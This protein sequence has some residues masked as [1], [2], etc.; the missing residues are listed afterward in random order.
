MFETVAD[1]I[2]TNGLLWG[3]VGKKI[4]SELLDVTTE[5]IRSAGIVCA[6]TGALLTLSKPAVYAVAKAKKLEDYKIRTLQFAATQAIHAA[7][8]GTLYVTGAVPI[9]KIYTISAG[10]AAGA[11]LFDSSLRTAYQTWGSTAKTIIATENFMLKT[12]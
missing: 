5:N 7:A 2:F 8:L 4:C 3:Y 6:A 10:I 11:F 9:E 12:S 1:K